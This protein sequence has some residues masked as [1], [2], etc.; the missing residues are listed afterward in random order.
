MK[1]RLFLVFAVLVSG[2]KSFSCS[3]YAVPPLNSQQVVGTDLILNWS[4]ATAWACSYNIFVEIRCQSNPGGAP[5]LTSLS[6]CINKPN[7]NTI[8]Y[9]ASH[10]IDIS[11]LCPGETYIFRGKETSCGTSNFGSSWTTKVWYVVRRKTMGWNT[12]H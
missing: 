8:P 5:V 2:F 4:S 3:P 11:G 6:G 9:P 1:R 10:V 7:S 12:I